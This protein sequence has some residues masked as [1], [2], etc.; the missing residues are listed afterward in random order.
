M[1]RALIFG[2]FDG[3]HPGHDYL[4]KQAAELADELYIAIPPDVIVKQLKGRE[5][6]NNL[7]SRISE[8][9]RRY[10]KAQV[11]E[12]DAEIGS[13]TVVKRIKPDVIALGYDQKELARDIADKLNIKTVTI[14]AFHPDKYK[15]SLL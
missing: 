11:I 1:T 4:V 5:P 7:A 15:S 6:T 9:S 2:A 8:V 3:L 10:P 13:Y 14:P 12:G